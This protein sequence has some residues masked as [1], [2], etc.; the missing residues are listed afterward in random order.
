[1]ITSKYS[2]CKI[3]H[4]IGAVKTTGREVCSAASPE[5]NEITETTGLAAAAILISLEKGE[6]EKWGIRSWGLPKMYIVVQR[7]V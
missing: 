5:S 6:G 7:C 1:M 2:I 3:D 4:L